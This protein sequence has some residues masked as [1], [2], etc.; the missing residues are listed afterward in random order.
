MRL[1]ALVALLLLS[2]LA[3]A[4]PVLLPQQADPDVP[5]ASAPVAVVQVFDEEKWQFTEG[6]RTRTLLVPDV[7]FD[8]VLLVWESRQVNEPW[9]RRF[10]VAI[11]GVEVLRGTTPRAWFNV[12]KDV[13]EYGALLPRGAEVPVSMHLGTWVAGHI[14]ASVRFEFYQAEPT[15]LVAPAAF[16]VVEDVAMWSYLSGGASV[17]RDVTFGET[18]PSRV[19][20][21]V[22]TS[23]HGQEGEFWW[24]ETPPA[25]ATFRVVVDGEDVG[26]LTAMPY[27][28]ALIGFSPSFV[29]DQV[30]HP[31]MWWSAFRAADVAGAHVGVGEVPA[32]RAEVDASQLHLF[33]GA[34]RVEIVQ[35]TG[36]GSW[37]TSASILVDA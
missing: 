28:Y 11:D 9:D 14:L 30:V 3:G 36:A 21:Q 18:A 25:V 34:R 13:T 15:A 5:A 23:G 8:R 35:D 12:T 22:H 29:T 1:L 33:T 17:A 6:Q 19:V 16:D 20:L 4:A 10:G 31:V 27:V 26:T 32:Y 24:M 7:D 2:P 37:V